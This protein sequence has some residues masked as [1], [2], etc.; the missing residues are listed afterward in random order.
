MVS[1]TNDISDINHKNSDTEKYK[2]LTDSQTFSKDFKFP[3]QQ[4]GMTKLGK[5]H[6]HS[7][8]LNWLE[9]FK[10]D[11]L[12]YSITE[13]GAYCKYY[14]L[15]PGA[16][17]G[18]LVKRPFHKCKDAV[19][20]FNAHFRDVKKDKT[21]GCCGNNMHSAVAVRAT[22]FLKCIEGEWLNINQVLGIKSQAQI[23]KNREVVKSIA[24][25]VHF[26]AKQSLPI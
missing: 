6:M 23:L 8:K 26:L 25:T 19:H 7:F 20:E 24:Q 1:A 16:E 5:P 9:E 18:L 4:F 11:G 2:I 14:R 3:K 13:D 22:E 15:F 17:R 12:I 21:K 10:P